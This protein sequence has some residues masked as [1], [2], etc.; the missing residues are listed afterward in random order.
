MSVYFTALAMSDT[1]ALWTGWFETLDTFGA[2]LSV[3]YHVHRD[4]YR[5]VIVDALCRIRVWVSYVFNQTSAWILVSMTVHRAVGIVWPHRTRRFLTRSNAKKVVVSI[6]SFSAAFHA[7]VLYGHSLVVADGDQKATCYYS[8]ASQRYSQFFYGVWMWV[9]MVVGTLLPFACLLVTNTV[10]VRRVG[11]SLREARVTLAEGRRSADHF[12]SRDKKL[13]SMTVTLIVTSV[14]FL[15]LV[16]PVA[17]FFILESAL[18][19]HTVEDVSLGAE[20]EL[21]S[22]VCMVLWLTNQSVNFY[23]YCLT[24]ARYRAQCL[25]LFGCGVGSGGRAPGV[26]TLT[27]A[28]VSSTQLSPNNK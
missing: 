2:T 21:A 19:L 8:F 23:L 11:R 13:S 17:V 1:M 16:A 14:V 3:V 18:A 26:H 25:G 20:I 22:T 15:L 5:D 24:G 9:D 6:V 4:Y 10:L 27:S 7:H 28:V 12:A